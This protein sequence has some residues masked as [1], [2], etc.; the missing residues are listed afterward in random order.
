VKIVEL[1]NLDKKDIPL[2]YRNEYSGTAVF[3][4]KTNDRI[5]KKVGFVL[6][7]HA[8]GEKEIEIDFLDDIEYPLLPLTNELKQHILELDKK[9]KL[10]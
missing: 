1:I 4:T 2:H 10:P 9:G 7:R 8:T 5:E 6:E 3:K